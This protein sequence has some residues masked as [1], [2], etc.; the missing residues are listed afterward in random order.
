MH[1]MPPCKRRVTQDTS[2]VLMALCALSATKPQVDIMLGKI[3]EGRFRQELACIP[4][5]STSNLPRS[6]LGVLATLAM[7][8]FERNAL[9]LDFYWF[10][11]TRSPC[12]G[13]I[14]SSSERDE[15]LVRAFRGEDGPS[16]VQTGSE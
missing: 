8:G 6:P 16:K 11:E 4:R 13:S 15:V 10:D 1:D 7:L 9:L 5:P 14:L 12:G 2:A 3:A